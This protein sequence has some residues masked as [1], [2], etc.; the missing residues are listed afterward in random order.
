[1]AKL[2][3]EI[4]NAEAKS[5]KFAYLRLSVIGQVKSVYNLIVTASYVNIVRSD[6]LIKSLYLKRAISR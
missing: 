3:K 5:A 4:I 2:S 6:F 1:M